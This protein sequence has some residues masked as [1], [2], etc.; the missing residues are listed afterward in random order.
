M[1]TAIAAKRDADRYVSPSRRARFA[2]GRSA[3]HAVQR[4]LVASSK[5]GCGKTTLATNLAVALARRGRRVWMIDADAQGS[6]AEW[7][8]ARAATR[9]AIGLTHSAEGGAVSTAVWSLKI[10][11]ATDVLVVDTPAGL[12][13]HQLS[14]LLR[15]CDTL[16][17]PIVPS[18]IDTRASSAFLAELVRALPVRSGAVRVGLVA[19][20]VKAR[21]LAARALPEFTGTLPFP[22]ITSL[23][24]A[25][26]YVLAAAAGHGVFDYQGPGVAGCHQDWAALLEWLIPEPRVASEA[27]PQAASPSAVVDAVA[28]ESPRTYT[29]E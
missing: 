18:G 4:I 14:E 28:S 16:L 5:G 2:A 22:L 6:S 7:V 25:Q 27:A 26:A 12:R 24:D 10:P 13:P 19:N 8:Q 15:R 3:G 17:V 9:P 21:T 11:P 23:R 29:A 20:R 1:P